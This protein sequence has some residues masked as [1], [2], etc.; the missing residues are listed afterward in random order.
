MHP[1]RDSKYKMLLLRRW[2]NKFNTFRH[3][4]ELRQA[5]ETNQLR[6]FDFLN[7][8]LVAGALDTLPPLYD[9][10]SVDL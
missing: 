3:L 10:K 9:E 7:L 1:P 5:S 2:F 8:K 4:G 6:D